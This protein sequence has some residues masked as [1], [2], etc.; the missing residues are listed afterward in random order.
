MDIFLQVLDNN[1][2][3]DTKGSLVYR[4][5]QKGIMMQYLFKLNSCLPVYRYIIAP[6]ENGAFA[7][8]EQMLHFP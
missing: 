4:Y 5:S 7:P 8:K 2:L 6:L 1:W 3:D